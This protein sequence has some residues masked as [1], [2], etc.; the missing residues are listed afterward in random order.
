MAEPLAD[1]LVLFGATGD[2]AYQQIFP[3]LYAL[4]NRGRLGIPVICTGRHPWTREQ[5]IERVRESVSKRDTLDETAFTALA[6]RLQ[7]IAGDYADPA[8]FAALDG[9]LGSAQ[10]PL[11][12]LA[13]PPNLFG[14]VARGLA[15]LGCGGEARLVVEK[16]FGRDLESAR[17]LNRVLHEFFPET[18]VYRIDHYLGKEPVLNL[19]YFRFANAFVEP[20]WN[21]HSIANVQITMAESFGVRGRGKFYEEVGA[22]RDVFQNHLLQVLALLAMEPPTDDTGPSIEA[23]KVAALKAVRPLRPADIVRGQYEGYRGES[24]VAPDSTVET[25]VAA[26]VAI[27]N[28]RW[29]GVPFGIRTGK[30]LTATVTEVRLQLKPPST[31]LFDAEATGHPNEI[32]FRLGPDVSVALSARLKARGEAMVGEPVQLVEHRTPGDEMR[33]YER[34]L[35]DALEGDRTLFGSQA[36]VEASW[37]I[38]EPVLTGQTPPQSYPAGSWGPRDAEDIGDAFGGWRITSD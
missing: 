27:D 33:A 21:A 38:V 12:Y 25:Y 26:K 20:L 16:P 32:L 37:A 11:F 23:A 2:L 17:A 22:I 30:C 15:A 31:V 4:S 28:P 24:G 1:A 6:S 29:A 13:I 10:R 36:A 14:P 8:T 34:L 3:A 9:A 18:A 35:G 5:L 7:Y 19:E